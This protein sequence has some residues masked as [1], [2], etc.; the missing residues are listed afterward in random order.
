MWNLELEGDLDIAEAIV[1]GALERKESRG[2][3]FRDDYPKRDDEKFLHH[4]MF[5]YT[6]KGAKLG[7]KKV[8]LGYFEPKERKY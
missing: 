7:K 3:Q 5:E 8:T 6:P 2:S 4:S 1:L